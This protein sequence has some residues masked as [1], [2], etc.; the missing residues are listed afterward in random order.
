M[1]ALIHPMATLRR[2]WV[3]SSPAFFG[4]MLSACV[5][6]SAP[7]P[8]DKVVSTSHED[9]RGHVETV[10]RFQNQVASDLITRYELSEDPAI[11]PSAELLVAE[12]RMQESCRYLN[13][14]VAISIDGKEP[15]IGLKLNLMKTIDD[16][17]AAAHKLASMLY[18]A[19]QSVVMEVTPLP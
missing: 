6:M 4:L 10:F 7:A 12:D 5:T 11:Q 19:G 3:A 9:F 15:D 8:G 1:A 14:V 18:G 2:A 17:D 13:E 16:C